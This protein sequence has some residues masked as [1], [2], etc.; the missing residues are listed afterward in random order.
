MYIINYLLPV[1]IVKVNTRSPPNDSADA[2]LQIQYAERREKEQCL[3]DNDLSLKL[4]ACCV[5]IL[6]IIFIWSILF[7]HVC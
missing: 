3:E 1:K 2:V 5:S 6:Y 7:F 4:S